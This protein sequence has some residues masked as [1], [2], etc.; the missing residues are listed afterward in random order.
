MGHFSVFCQGHLIP[1]DPLIWEEDQ[2]KKSAVLSQSAPWRRTKRHYSIIPYSS[3]EAISGPMM[4][5]NPTRQHLHDSM[6][7]CTAPRA[8]TRGERRQPLGV[9]P[10]EDRYNEGRQRNVAKLHLVHSWCQC[11]NVFL[12]THR[13]R[14]ASTGRTALS[15]KDR[16][17]RGVFTGNHHLPITTFIKR[18]QLLLAKTILINVQLMRALKTIF[19]FLFGQML[20]PYTIFIKVH[21]SAVSLPRKQLSIENSARF[22]FVCLWSGFWAPVVTVCRLTCP[23]VGWEWGQWPQGAG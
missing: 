18:K 13:T 22:L 3:T 5:W 11:G 8:C 10:H 23:P 9:Q 20:S 12:S 16:A 1:A 2:G 21:L 4:V 19:L 15:Y 17:P 14:M 6:Q 7:A